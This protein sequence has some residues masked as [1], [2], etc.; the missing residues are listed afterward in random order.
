[1]SKVE[2]GEFIESAKLHDKI[3]KSPTSLNRGLNSSENEEENLSELVK[4]LR[5]EN[6]NMEAKVRASEVFSKANE[7]SIGS[8][9][10]AEPRRGLSDS[11]N[12]IE[13]HTSTYKGFNATLTTPSSSVA[14]RNSDILD[15]HE[16]TSTNNIITRGE[17]NMDCS[18]IKFNQ[19]YTMK[20]G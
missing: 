5:Q 14:V 7:L 10:R 16:S 13:N 4:R 6:K 19:T 18:I 1:M 15:T 2:S 11:P 3:S 8:R 17:L 20:G 12:L 9:K